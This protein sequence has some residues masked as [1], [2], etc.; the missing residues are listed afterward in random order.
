MMLTYLK[1]ITQ[2]LRHVQT[3][4]FPPFPFPL[5]FCCLFCLF[6]SPLRPGATC[7]AQVVI[8]GWVKSFVLPRGDQPAGLQ[9]ETS[10]I[11]VPTS[12]NM[13]DNLSKVL[14]RE[15]FIR[16]VGNALN[17]DDILPPMPL[18]EGECWENIWWILN[19]HP[20]YRE[21]MCWYTWYTY[22]TFLT[23]AH[24]HTY[25]HYN[26]RAYDTHVI[27]ASGRSTMHSCLPPYVYYS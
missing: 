14:P 13:T 24:V 16:C 3:F 19:T 27:W 18:N 17:P 20:P 23:T 7:N 21:N 22:F 6:L 15:T 8:L 26:R 9:K 11:H 4:S 12:L 1:R 25:R 10:K 5:W 2:E